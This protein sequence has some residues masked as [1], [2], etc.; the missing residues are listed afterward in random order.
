MLRLTSIRI[1]N[2]GPFYGE[3]LIDLNR[4]HDSPISI[5]VGA[6]GSGKTSIIAALEWALYGQEYLKSYHLIINKDKDKSGVGF[7]FVE[8]SFQYGQRLYSLKR[9][10]DAQEN[11]S[12][13]MQTSLSIFDVTETTVPVV[14]ENPQNFIN[15]IAPIDVAMLSYLDC[16]RISDLADQSSES[17]TILQVIVASIAIH[18]DTLIEKDCNAHIT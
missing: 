5:I 13:K 3:Q 2:L 4:K 10:V 6:N 17:T 1:S 16:E 8:L 15:L 18:F 14:I 7:A 11:V 12:P 9:Q